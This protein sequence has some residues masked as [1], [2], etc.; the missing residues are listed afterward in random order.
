MRNWVREGDSERVRESLGEGKAEAWA[1]GH[2]QE[3]RQADE[4]A[5]KR[6]TAATRNYSDRLGPPH[7]G[8]K[9]GREP[10][11]NPQLPA[12]QGR[13]RPPGPRGKGLG[14]WAVEEG[15]RRGPQFPHWQSQGVGRP[16]RR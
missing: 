16:E 1:E 14:G 3:E 5:G 10:P 15:S 11:P 4:R 6:W 2:R 7:G 8:R 13:T 9:E 12:P